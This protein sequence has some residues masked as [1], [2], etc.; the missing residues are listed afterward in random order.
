[1]RAR[2][3]RMRSSSKARHSDGAPAVNFGLVIAISAIPS[4]WS[5]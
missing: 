3:A 5:D 2:L 4:A 1:M